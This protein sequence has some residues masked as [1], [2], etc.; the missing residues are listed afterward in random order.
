MRANLPRLNERTH[1]QPASPIVPKILSF[2]GSYGTAALKS[3]VPRFYL[4]VVCHCDAVSA[5]A[6]DG[7]KSACAPSGRRSRVVLMLAPGP[8]ALNARNAPLPDQA[9]AI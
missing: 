6:C 9:R 3:I 7:G 4:L 5:V 2:E 8:P 1:A